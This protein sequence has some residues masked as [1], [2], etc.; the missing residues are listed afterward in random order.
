MKD[1]QILKKAVEKA[2]ENGWDYSFTK[3]EIDKLIKGYQSFIFSHSFAKAFWGK[4]DI[5]DEDG[6]PR[7]KNGCFPEYTGSNEGLWWKVHLQQ[8]VLEEQPLKY[9]EKW[10]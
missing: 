6:M 4:E 2:V 10:L 7:E 5:Y 1:E 8:M 9:I 3:E